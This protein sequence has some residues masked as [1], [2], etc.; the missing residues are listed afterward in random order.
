[1][2]RSG[3]S[4][5]ILV[6][7][8][9]ACMTGPASAKCTVTG[10]EFLVSGE[11]AEEI[12]ALFADRLAQSR[13]AQ[14]RVAQSD[15]PGDA[16]SPGSVAISL[17]KMGSAQAS[18]VSKH[19]DQQVKHPVVAVDVTDRPLRSSD[20]LTLADAVAEMLQSAARND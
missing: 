10:A 17:T 12:C 6:F 7:V 4:A 13:I 20:I 8:L 16:E 14:S 5:A 15:F 1:M 11:T 2:A 3:A 18:V 9:G 19:G